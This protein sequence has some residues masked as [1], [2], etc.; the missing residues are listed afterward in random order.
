M[1]LLNLKFFIVI[2]TLQCAA[3]VNCKNDTSRN[4]KTYFLQ[5]KNVGDGELSY[6]P[7]WTKHIRSKNS[8]SPE[9]YEILGRLIQNVSQN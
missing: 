3:Y 1:F 4:G 5:L 6:K 2:V 9:E 8:K 7:I